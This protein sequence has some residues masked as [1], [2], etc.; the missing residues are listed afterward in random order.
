MNTDTVETSSLEI[1]GGSRVTM[2]S[3]GET[4]K[5]IVHRDGTKADVVTEGKMLF[6][7]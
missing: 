2:K 5:T 4:K 1:H 7:K 3:G 6:R